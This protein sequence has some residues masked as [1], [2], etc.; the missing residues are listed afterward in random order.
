MA[1]R[2][3]YYSVLTDCV[4]D[5]ADN[6]YT[7]ERLAFWQ[8]KLRHAAEA[9]FLSMAQMES[10]MR[11]ALGAVYA[12]MI[13]NGG[14]TK[15]HP[16]L[17]RF[18]LDKL[19]PELQIALQRRQAASRDLIK[20]NRV[21][22]IAQEEQRLAGWASSLPPGGSDTVARVATKQA[23]RKSLASLPYRERFVIIDQSHKL[24]AN[25]NETIARGGNAIAVEWH[26]HGATQQGYDYR[27]K[28][29]ARN[30]L[31]YLLK[32]NWAQEQGLVKAGPAGYYEDVTAFAE[33]PNC[34]CYG[35]WIYA[36]RQL[37]PDMLTAKGAEAL[38]LAR[39]KIAEM[40]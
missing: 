30:G 31:I 24:A 10:Q 17:P 40:A 8:N 14:A 16:G 18:T 27:P 25:L 28:H 23:I 34:R 35:R 38:A 36:L 9:S 33:E 12:R 29:L 22:A 5:L 39:T 19:R 7:P 4:N 6:G 37:P 15:Y 3:D 1:S 11:D 21:N 13:R 20:L 26:D 2:T 32:G